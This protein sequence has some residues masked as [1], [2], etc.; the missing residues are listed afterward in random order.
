MKPDEVKM[1]AVIAWALV[2]SAIAVSL[3]SSVSNWFLVTALGVLP[4]LLI[5][6]MWR[7][8]APLA[9]VPVAVR[10]TRRY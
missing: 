7:P 1:A 5:V 8:P 9:P 6:W 3:V 4:P 10:E 2:W